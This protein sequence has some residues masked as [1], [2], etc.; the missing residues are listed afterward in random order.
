MNVLVPILVRI[1]YLPREPLSSVHFMGNSDVFA[2]A[3][4]MFTEGTE[5]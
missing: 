2:Q 4:W 1:C 5:H 3:F